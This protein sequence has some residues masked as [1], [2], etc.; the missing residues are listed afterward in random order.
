MPA[1]AVTVAEGSEEGGSGWC[2]SGDGGAGVV[3][4]GKTRARDC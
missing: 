1:T 4:L 3:R 2:G